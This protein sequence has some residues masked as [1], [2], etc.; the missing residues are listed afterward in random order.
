MVHYPK[1]VNPDFAR[2][3]RLDSAS[4]ARQR[5]IKKRQEMINRAVRRKNIYKKLLTKANLTDD[6]KSKIRKKIKQIDAENRKQG[7]YIH[8]LRDRNKPTQLKQTK[9]KY[10]NRS[11][12]VS[13]FATKNGFVV[14]YKIFPLIFITEEAIDDI[15]DLVRQKFESSN[16][17]L[18]TK[19]TP[20]SRHSIKLVFCDEYGDFISSESVLDVDDVS[21][22]LILQIHNVVID[23]L[24]LGN[25]NFFGVVNLQYI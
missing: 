12:R 22:T 9:L 19:I 21:E 2:F 5:V 25:V 4:N 10:K 11:S 8:K 16:R 17:I 18:G 13:S 6:K 7:R 24:P 14:K 20:N 1:I 3:D 15:V 23:S